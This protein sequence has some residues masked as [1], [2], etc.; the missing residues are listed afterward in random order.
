MAAR[1]PRVFMDIAIGGARSGRL[2]MELFKDKVPKVRLA[3]L[4][5]HA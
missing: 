3:S 1:N 4:K 2:V 5:V